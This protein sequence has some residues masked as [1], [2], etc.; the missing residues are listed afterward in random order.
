M[1]YAGFSLEYI[2][3]T[4]SHGLSVC[5]IGEVCFIYRCNTVHCYVP[6]YVFFYHELLWFVLPFV[7]L[8]HRI[9]YDTWV[10]YMC[11]C[12]YIYI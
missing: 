4:F 11:V 6:M 10:C 5:C 7:L 1:G 12:V 2:Y 8:C 9:M 3:V